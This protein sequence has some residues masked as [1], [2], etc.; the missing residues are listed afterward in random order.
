[1]AR[2]WKAGDMRFLGFLTLLLVLSLPAVAQPFEGRFTNAKDQ[3]VNLPKLMSDVSFKKLRSGKLRFVVHTDK[4]MK[5][6]LKN[7]ESYTV[8]VEG[9]RRKMQAKWDANKLETV[10]TRH[11]SRGRP[12]SE[13]RSTWTISDDGKKLTRKI[14]IPP[15]TQDDGSEVKIPFEGTAVYYR[16]GASDEPD[17][18]EEPDTQPTP[19]ETKAPDKD[20]GEEKPPADLAVM[21][22]RANPNTYTGEVTFDVQ[23][24]N[25]GGHTAT[26]VKARFVVVGPDGKT[27]ISKTVYHGP[28]PPGGKW[29]FTEEYKHRLGGQAVTD[30]DG[31]TFEITVTPEFKSKKD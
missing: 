4:P 8:V 1:M 14:L 12:T 3:N 30:Q 29:E 25:T 10:E 20:P 2:I 11:S 7:G 19:T 18:P 27:W 15:Y 28:I 16:V 13:D 31:R 21:S 17:E 22:K 6:S 5:F 9:K 24:Q 23:I 26:D